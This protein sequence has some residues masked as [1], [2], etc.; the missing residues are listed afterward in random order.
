MEAGSERKV[1]AARAWRL[2]YGRE[3]TTRDL[4]GAVA[5]LTDATEAL[6]KMSPPVTPVG[7]KGGSAS[8]AGEAQPVT[9]KPAKPPSPEARAVAAFC[10]ALLSSNRLLYV[11]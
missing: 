11:D 7:S 1:Q 10:P 2:A 4:S 5:F 3:P 6:R 9:A 8:K